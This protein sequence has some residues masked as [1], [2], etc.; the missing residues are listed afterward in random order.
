MKDLLLTLRVMCL[1]GD[2]PSSTHGLV[3]WPQAGLQA[4]KDNMNWKRA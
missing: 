4:S 2:A 1:E 3:T